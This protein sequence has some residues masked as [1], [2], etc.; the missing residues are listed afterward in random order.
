MKGFITALALLLF[1]VAAQAH[2]ASDRGIVL[3]APE[4]GFTITF[5]VK[6]DVTSSNLS[7]KYR[8]MQYTYRA[9]VKD[10][11]YTLLVVEFPHV[12]VQLYLGD[13][14]LQDVLSNYAKE[15]NTEMHKPYH[16]TVGGQKGLGVVTRDAHLNEYHLV[17]VA[18]SEDRLFLLRVI[19]RNGVQNSLE[20]QKF[21][22]SFHIID[23]NAR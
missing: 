19:G 8:V 17:E 2:A 12:D 11:E 5:P 7:E 1:S 23:N 9:V 21:R 10:H 13:G 3:N 22:A 6:P 4:H 16:T 15:S 14:F 18:Y 20:T